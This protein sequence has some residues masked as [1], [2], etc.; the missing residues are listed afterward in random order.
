MQTSNKDRL[1]TFWK[2]FDVKAKLVEKL[3]GINLY[4]EDLKVSFFRSGKRAGFAGY[5]I[6]AEGTKWR[7]GFNWNSLCR[8]PSTVLEDTLPH[9]LA[10]IVCGM[11]PELGG[12]NH[13]AVWQEVAK[14]LGSTGDTKHSM[15]FVYAR[16]ETFN[17]GCPSGQVIPLRR[18]TVVKMLEG[19]SIKL[20]KTGE[21][22][23]IKHCKLE[24]VG[25]QGKPVEPISVMEVGFQPTEHW[26]KWAQYN[27]A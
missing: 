26:N 15:S 24:L 27:C 22:I 3:Y 18:S 7:M 6:T 11:K 14:N 17:L 12:V 5:R 25:I 10:H 8:H 2:A 9:E 19:S 23:N 1:N 4:K 21:V 20:R 16:G 13:N